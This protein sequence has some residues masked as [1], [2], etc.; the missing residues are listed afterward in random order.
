M[1]LDDPGIN[2]EQLLNLPIARVLAAILLGGYVIF[3][4]LVIRQIQLL[5]KVLRTNL[6][7]L[8]L[9]VSV[10]HLIFAVSVLLA[11]LIIL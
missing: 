6:T 3:A 1:F 5:S 10:L 8:L 9:L 11:A 2:I 4:I 7:P